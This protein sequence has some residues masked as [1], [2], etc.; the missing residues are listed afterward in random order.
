MVSKFN[1]TIKGLD[2]AIKS[3]K[4]N[5]E[6]LR[7]IDNVLAKGSRKIEA[8]AKINASTNPRVRTGFLRR[9]IGSEKV[10]KF[11]YAVYSGANY[12]LFQEEGTRHGIRPKYFIKKAVINEVP[13][14][15]RNISF[16][17]E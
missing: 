14:I 9:T 7:K 3:E 16:L 1:V 12:G 6:N 11:K 15:Q 17:V 4:D 5:V 2:E 10:D 8:Q 13:K